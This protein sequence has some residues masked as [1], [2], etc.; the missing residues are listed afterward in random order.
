MRI[1]AFNKA[2]L[3]RIQKKQM[4][5]IMFLCNWGDGPATLLDRYTYQ[6]PG[7][8][9]IWEHLEAT[10]DPKKVD[11]IV[12]M[13]GLPK[14]VSENQIPSSM[15]LYFQREPEEIVPHHKFVHDQALFKGSYDVHYHLS[16][17]QIRKPFIA[18]RDMKK[19]SKSKKLSAIISGKRFTDGQNKRLETLLRLY[20]TYPDID[21]Y[22]RG[23]TER[24]FGTAYKGELNYNM[25]CKF[26]GLIDYKYSLTFENSSHDNYFTEKLIDCFL[27]WTKPLYWGCSNIQEYFPPDSYAWIDIYSPFVTEILMDEM[28]RPVNYDA[29]KEARELVLFKYNLW[30]SVQN[31]LKQAKVIN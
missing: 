6:T 4:K 7:H 16:T 10:Q 13:D 8:D 1:G 21:I 3:F 26:N 14:N 2:I 30:P 15:K 17:W 24:D 20:N 9:G 22:G 23:L 12:I 11:F 25:Y 18:L 28:S 29:L 19:P 27:A 5:K 31:V